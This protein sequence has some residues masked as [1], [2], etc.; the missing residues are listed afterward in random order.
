MTEFEI[1]FRDKLLKHLNLQD[2]DPQ[3][4]TSES[5]LFGEGSGLELDSIDAI[6]IEVFLKN[7]YQI[8]IH[9]SER[10]KDVFGTVGGLAAFAER[11]RERNV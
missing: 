4:I 10:T 6:E 11:N 3:E 5:T 2:I 9:P 8:D 7:E 1:E